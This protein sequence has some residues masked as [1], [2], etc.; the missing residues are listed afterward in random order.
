M[1]A[2]DYE[3]ALKILES[4]D[5][6][7]A[8]TLDLERAALLRAE[9]LI[10]LQRPGEAET[11]YADAIILNPGVALG[12]NAAPRLF[13]ALERVR[14]KLVGTVAIRSN[15]PG[16]M[17]LLDGKRVGPLPVTVLVVAGKHQVK[18][19]ADDA[20]ASKE[21]VAFPGKT[22]DISLEV[23]ASTR[24]VASVEKAPAKSPSRV[25]P[26]TL[27]G[28][29]VAAAISGGVL[30]GTA[31]SWNSGE[32]ST[33]LITDALAQR[34]AARTRHLIGLTAIGVGAAAAITGVIV[35]L[36]G[37]SDGPTAVIAPTSNGAF[38]GVGGVF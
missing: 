37:S 8:S 18:I 30:V 16:A 31:L 19:D 3:R 21:I 33:V 11:A 12:P 24:A 6:A 27:I 9:C 15:L 38:V 23:T 5:S 32:R 20:A 14:A 36:A 2:A 10:T 1:T 13:A 35:L 34:E 7:T 4:L 25:L 22:T 29:G 28:V 26:F 17:A